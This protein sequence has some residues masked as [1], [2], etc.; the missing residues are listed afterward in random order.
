M[1]LTLIRHGA[2]IGRQ[3]VFRGRSEPPLSV[4]GWKQLEQSA[5]KWDTPRVDYLYTSASVR[6]AA[7]ARKWTSARNMEP[8]TMPALREIDFGIWEECTP[9]EARSKD[10]DCF[11]T[12]KTD[13][14]NWSAPGGEAYRDFR[15]RVLE[16][17]HEI[18]Q[19]RADHIGVLTHGGVI[20][21]LLCEILSMRPEHMQRIAIDYGCCCRVW[22]AGWRDSRL[23]SLENP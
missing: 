22:Y 13:V 18:A 21:V 20:R 1:L 19:T 12:M 9:D 5:Q 3:N 14:E 11:T 17:L 15:A 23:L 10:C 8:I 16:A 4:E 6:C 2:V 7:F